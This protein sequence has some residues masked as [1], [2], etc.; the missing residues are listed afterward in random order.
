MKGVLCKTATEPRFDISSLHPRR[1]LAAL[2]YPMKMRIS[3]RGYYKIPGEQKSLLILRWHFQHCHKSQSKLIL[4]S[5]THM[6][7]P[8]TS[9]AVVERC[10]KNKFNNSTYRSSSPNSIV[11][12]AS[13]AHYPIYKLEVHFPQLTSTR[14]ALHRT[15]SSE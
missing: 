1:S 6:A 4:P 13:Y 12:I 15:T 7:G 8:F 3:H 14:L 10:S 5:N 11:L 9:P 2:Q